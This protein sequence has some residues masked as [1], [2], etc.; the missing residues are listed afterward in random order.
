MSVQE[1]LAKNLENWTRFAVFRLCFTPRVQKGCLHLGQHS[2]Q[3]SGLIDWPCLSHTLLVIAPYLFQ[4]TLNSTNSTWLYPLLSNIYIYKDKNPTTTPNPSLPSLLKNTVIIN[5]VCNP[6]DL[7]L[8]FST[9]YL[10][11]CGHLSE[12]HT[13]FKLNDLQGSTWHSPAAYLSDFT[14]H[15]FFC[16]HSTGHRAFVPFFPNS[17]PLQFQL[18]K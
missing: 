7:P 13:Y 12:T 15:H 16:A 18:I 10:N 8:C 9:T 5:L 1:C 2:R 17:T 3:I 4:L 14:S 11:K 6:S